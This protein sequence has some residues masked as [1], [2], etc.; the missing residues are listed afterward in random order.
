MARAASVTAGSIR[1]RFGRSARPGRPT[2]TPGLRRSVPGRAAARHRAGRCD[3]AGWRARLVARGLRDLGVVG[4]R[5]R[6]RARLAGVLADERL[7]ELTR[8]G[9]GPLV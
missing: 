1:V 4:R 7:G 3:T 6:A 9:V 2:G 5:D 8:V